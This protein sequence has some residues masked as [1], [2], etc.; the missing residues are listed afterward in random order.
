M[1]DNHFEV[2][3]GTTEERLA[4]VVMLSVDDD[5]FNYVVDGYSLIGTNGTTRYYMTINASQED[6]NY[7]RESFIVLD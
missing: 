6:E 1:S 3:D 2:I 7:I 4:S 5:V